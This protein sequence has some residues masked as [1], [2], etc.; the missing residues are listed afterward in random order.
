MVQF[1]PEDSV[2]DSVPH[3]L[4]ENSS[5]TQNLENASTQITAEMREHRL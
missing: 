3:C 2:G 4:R 5:N 1:L